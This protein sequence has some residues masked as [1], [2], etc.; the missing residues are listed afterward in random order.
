M[1][2]PMPPC[3]VRRHTRTSH[4]RLP[5]AMRLSEHHNADDVARTRHTAH[6]SL[7]AGSFLQV[8][9]FHLNFLFSSKNLRELKTQFTTYTPVHKQKEIIT[10]SLARGRD[11]QR[12]ERRRGVGRRK[13]IDRTAKQEIWTKPRPLA[14]RPSVVQFENEKVT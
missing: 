2:A 9:I 4:D 8:L 13:A 3:Y 10:G 1:L 5:R 6:A 14:N 7:C 12:R 11:R